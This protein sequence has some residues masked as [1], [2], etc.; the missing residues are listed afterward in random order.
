MLISMAYAT[1]SA[2]AAQPP[3]AMEAFALNML[4]IVIL[5]VMFYVLLIMPQQKRFKQ[6]RAMLEA[7]KKGDRI[8]MTSGFVGTLDKIKEG[9]NEVVV[10]L[11][12]GLKVTA[13]RSAI[14]GKMDEK[15]EDKKA[16]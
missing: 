1:G 7:L 9:E 13:L 12:G 16:A 3:S 5:V 14:Q 6:H 15:K 8:L 4:L 10:D 2:A 11:G